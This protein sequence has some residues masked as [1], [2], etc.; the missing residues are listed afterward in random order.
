MTRK[1]EAV[2]TDLDG[3]LLGPNQQ[4]G[5]QDLKT[6]A[7]L[8]AQGIPVF[9]A[10]GRHQCL[11]RQYAEL[12][13]PELPAITS[14]GAL[15]Y[16]FAQE[17]ILEMDVMPVD[18]VAALLEFTV[19][20]GLPYYVYT[21]RQCFLNPANADSEYYQ[22]DLNLQKISRPGEVAMMEPGFDPTAY[23]VLKFM[24]PECSREQYLRLLETPVGK[25][26]EL[27][28]SGND[29]L[30]VN[31]SNSTKGTALAKLARRF[32][33]SPNNTLVMGDN[34]NDLTMLSLAG[35]PVVPASA[36]SYVRD[37]ACLVT[38]PSGGNP[39]THAILTLFPQLL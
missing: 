29:F 24:I 38:T 25:R 28:F 2:V 15:L 39:L 12:V 32:G 35:Y 3:T 27:A 26:V 4:I 1:L 34:G 11:C 33:F 21:D 19:E 37:T 16:D 20:Q 18:D 7:A 8:K 22:F 6:I 30:D 9:M 10:T 17:K 13:G 5:A 31:P 23:T 36:E 14:N